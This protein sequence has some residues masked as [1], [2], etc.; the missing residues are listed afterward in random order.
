MALL[1]SQFRFPRPPFPVGFSFFLALF[2]PLARSSHFCS[3]S[4]CLTLAWVATKNIQWSAFNIL[5][6]KHP[7]ATEATLTKKKFLILKKFLI[8]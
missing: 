4:A 3:D 1:S 5:G 8:V 7:I 2:S 6:G